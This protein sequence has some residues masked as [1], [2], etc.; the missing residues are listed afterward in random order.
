MRRACPS[1]SF[2]ASLPSRYSFAAVD[3]RTTRS[4]AF[5]ANSHTESGCT[6]RRWKHLTLP[7]LP[8]IPLRLSLSFSFTRSLSLTLVQS[9]RC[10]GH[11]HH[12]PCPCPRDEHRREKRERAEKST[13]LRLAPVQGFQVGGGGAATSADDVLNFDM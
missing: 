13:P 3:K 12:T 11:H 7:C 5:A 10:S 2:S 6:R 8:P 9:R 4:G 1:R